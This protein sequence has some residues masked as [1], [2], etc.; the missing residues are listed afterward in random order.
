MTALHYESF[1]REGSAMS[2]KLIEFESPD[3]WICQ[4][5]VDDDGFFAPRRWKGR[6]GTDGGSSTGDPSLGLQQYAFRSAT[7]AMM[8]AYRERL[9]RRVDLGT[10]RRNGSAS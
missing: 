10:D 1:E 2:T 9:Q 7:E 4:I 5:A 8:A 3:G 6:Q